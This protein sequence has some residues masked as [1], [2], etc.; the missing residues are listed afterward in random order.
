MLLPACLGVTS[1]H[2]TPPHP[3]AGKRDTSWQRMRTLPLACLFFAT[4][5]L[6][7]L[8]PPFPARPAGECEKNKQYM[9][10]DAF[11]LGNCRASCGDCEVCK[12]GDRGEGGAGGGAKGGGRCTATGT[13]GSGAAVKQGSQGLSRSGT[14]GRRVQHEPQ[15][16]ACLCACVASTPPWLP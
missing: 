4:A 8:A 3:D 9:R 11:Q 12:E 13:G 1:P 2:P 14:P 16:C 10:G 5:V 15:R 6:S 7:P